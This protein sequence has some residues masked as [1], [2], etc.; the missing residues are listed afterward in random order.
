GR[1]LRE[2]DLDGEASGNRYVVWNATLERL[3]CA[4][5]ESATRSADLLTT[6][7]RRVAIRDAAG[8]CV[9]VDCTPAFDLYAKALDAYT[10][11]Q[12]AA[13]TG[14]AAADIVKAAAMLRPHQA[15]AY[16]AWSGVGMHTNATQTERAI[17]TLYAL[18]GAFDTRGSNREWTKQPANAVSSYAM[19]SPQQRAKALGLA[20]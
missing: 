13:L 5:E 2:R 15:I 7:V 18:T 3:E 17:A 6:G 10:P 19:L 4:G 16:H 9:E 12:A 8:R 14:V 11:E 1:F 20:E